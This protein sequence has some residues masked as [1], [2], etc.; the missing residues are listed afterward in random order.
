MQLLFLDSDYGLPGEGLGGR[1]QG[2]AQGLL[3]ASK[4]PVMASHGTALLQ[5]ALNVFIKPV[6]A[7]KAPKGFTRPSRALEGP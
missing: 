3:T 2:V 5:T 7:Y 1:G 4:G 6:R